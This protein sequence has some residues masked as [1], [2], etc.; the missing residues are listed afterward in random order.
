MLRLSIKSTLA[1]KRRLIG[2]ALSVILGVAFLAGTFIFTD[3]IK[4]TFDNLFADVYDETDAAV[5]SRQSLD[6]QF[7]DSVRDRIPDTVIAD[8]AQIP[9]VAAAVGDVQGFARIV[10]ADGDPLGRDDGPPPSAAT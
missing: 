9:G 3:T 10:G 6:V 1:H 8:V 7:G 2:T 5:R 4:R